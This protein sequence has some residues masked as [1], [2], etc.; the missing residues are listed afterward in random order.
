[1]GVYALSV[2]LSAAVVL[3]QVPTAE[4]CVFEEIPLGEFYVSPDAH[5]T[6]ISLKDCLTRCFADSWCSMVLYYAEVN[7]Q[8]TYGCQAFVESGSTLDLSHMAGENVHLYRIQRD[9]ER[10]D[11]PKL[12]SLQ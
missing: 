12:S 11:C 7:G 9:I 1:M 4:L 6:G 10:S 8:K 2:V 5:A 3:L